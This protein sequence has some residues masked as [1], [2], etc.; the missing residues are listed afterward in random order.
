ME[1]AVVA[2]S[3]LSPCL[4]AFAV[5]KPGWRRAVLA[6][7]ALGSAVAGLTLSTALNF[8]PQHAMAWQTSATWQGLLLGFVVACLLSWLPPRVAAVVGVGSIVAMVSL[9]ARAP[10]DPYYTVSLAAWEQGR[11]VHFHGAAQWAGWLW[12]YVAMVVL[13]QRATS[14]RG[15][16]RA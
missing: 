2:V 11:F 1:A 16:G 4:L 15:V 14:R 8:G 12:P 10:A 3:L 13:V 6:A 9:A 7:G 5:S